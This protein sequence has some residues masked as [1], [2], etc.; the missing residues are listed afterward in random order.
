MFA[1]ADQVQRVG[2]V[3]RIG[4]QRMAGDLAVED[5]AGDVG[6]VG[7]DL[8]P[9]LRPVSGV[10]RTKPTNSLQ[11]VSSLMI[12]IAISTVLRRYPCGSKRTL[13]VTVVALVDKALSRQRRQHR[14]FATSSTTTIAPALSQWPSSSACKSLRAQ[15]LP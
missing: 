3:E 4:A 13:G 9:A 6:V 1:F 11:K 10:T 7:R 5:L 2:E 8:A 14:S 15:P 12:F